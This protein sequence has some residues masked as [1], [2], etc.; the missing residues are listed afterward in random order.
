MT[1]IPALNFTVLFV[2]ARN[3]NKEPQND[4]LVLVPSKSLHQAD[5]HV[6]C[7]LTHLYICEGALD[8]LLQS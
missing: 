4:L 7:A 6:K 3:P 2:T 5:L 8:E 1:S